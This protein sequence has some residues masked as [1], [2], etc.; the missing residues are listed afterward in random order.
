MKIIFLCPSLDRKTGWNRYSYDV[1]TRIAKHADVVVLCQEK[2]PS[3]DA[4]IRQIAVLRKPLDYLAH[5]F[6]VL[7]DFLRVRRAI[8]REMESEG[9][10]YVHCTV[11]GYA[12]FVPFL[13]GLSVRTLMT[14]HG[15][16][17]VL[18]LSSMSMRW[19]YKWMYKRVDRVITVSGYT[20]RHLL[21]HAESFLPASKVVA[22]N[23]GVDFEEKPAHHKTSDD[24]F[25]IL[26]VGELKNRKGGHHLL[27]VARYLKENHSLNFHITFVGNVEKGRPYY[28]QLQDYIDTYSLQDYV[29][30]AGMIPQEELDTYYS[31]VDLFALLS[32]HEGGHYEGYPLVFHE[33]AMWG[34]PTVGTFDCG[35]EDAINDGVSGIVV[36]PTR[37][38]EIAQK[39]AEIQSGAFALSSEKCK[40]W[41]RENDWDKKDLLKMYELA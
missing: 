9:E 38:E 35:A 17:S 10:N 6:W 8:A 19:L 21:K 33:A 39:I 3:V 25:R 12:V 11:E 31:E 4:S 7:K 22:V 27:A 16:Y 18:P 28:A 14:T 15:T 13:R 37:H 36:D 41:A 34:I 29:H 1:I 32:V 20:K 40:D 24:V 5:P 26:T 30:F 23:N 2:D